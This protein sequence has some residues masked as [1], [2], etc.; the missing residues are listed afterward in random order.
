[1]VQLKNRTIQAMDD[2]YFLIAVQDTFLKCFRSKALK[3]KT[4]GAK[5]IY[6][7]TIHEISQNLLGLLHIFLEIFK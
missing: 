6:C 2:K 7:L 4:V 5:I 1:M 3:Q